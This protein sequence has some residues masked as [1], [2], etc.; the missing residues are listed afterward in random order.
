MSRMAEQGVSLDGGRFIAAR[1]RE[2]TELSSVRTPALRASVLLLDDD[3]T[4]ID[5]L[6]NDLYAADFGTLVAMDPT[7]ACQ[8]IQRPGLLAVVFS[9][10]FIAQSGGSALIA[11]LRNSTS[12]RLTFIVFS[13]NQQ[14][15]LEA[16]TCDIDDYLPSD[17]PPGELVHLL[18]DY[19]L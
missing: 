10:Q 18:D 12:E 16:A 14:E 11:A 6:T 4:R 3:P 9:W 8:L 17:H 2:P 5:T 15:L 13:C 19:V 7:S 1:R